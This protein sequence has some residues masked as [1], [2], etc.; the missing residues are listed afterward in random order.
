[1]LNYVCSKKSDIAIRLE[2][3]DLFKTTVN[4]IQ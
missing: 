3:Y 4:Y 1:M 2:M